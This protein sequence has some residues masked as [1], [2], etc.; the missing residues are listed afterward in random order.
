MPE[1]KLQAGLYRSSFFDELFERLL[2]LVL[3]NPSA[4]PVIT[5]PTAAGKS[6]MALKLAAKTSGEIVSVDAMQVYRGFDIGTAKPSR[7]DRA[8][9]PHH[10]LDIL[11]PC[12]E[13]SVAALTERAVKLLQSLLE[14]QKKPI[15]C[16]GSVQYVSALLDGIRFSAPKP[17]PGLR[18]R[19]AKQ[20]DE[21]GLEASWQR[22]RQMDPQAAASVNPADRRRIIRF[23]ELLQQTGMTKTAL[24]EMSRASGPPF[25]FLPV[26]LDLSPRQALYD[27]ID[28]RVDAMYE[29]G[30]LGEVRGLM[31]QYPR[32]RECPAF[33]GI[34]YRQAVSLL[35]GEVS[36][37]ESRELT[38][39]ATRRYAKRQ[40]TWLRQ[41]KDLT[42]LLLEQKPA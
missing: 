38:A 31:E 42:I 25:P 1:T 15:L 2:S 16:G 6:R 28:R 8:A 39:R 26:W 32:Y 30:L 13:I 35:E 9:I 41:R 5:G 37:R 12:E 17:D 11:D 14:A 23:F 19:I 22:M 18:S 7:E 10:L 20:V 36:E 29:A 34:G 40:Q 24:N 4:I 3:Q 33:R 21:R 27:L